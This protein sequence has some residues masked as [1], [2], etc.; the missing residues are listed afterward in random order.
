MDRPGEPIYGPAKPIHVVVTVAAAAIARWLA[1]RG[2]QPSDPLEA[3]H[4]HGHQIHRGRGRAEGARWICMGEEQLLPDLLRCWWRCAQ[5]VA[6]RWW[7]RICYWRRS[8]SCCCTDPRAH[9]PREPT[10]RCW[11]LHVRRERE[12]AIVLGDGGECHHAG[13]GG[14][15]KRCTACA[16]RAERRGRP[17]GEGGAPHARR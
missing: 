3:G 12:S 17:W 1:T 16:P 15:E 13:E 14:L 8:S 4:H 6:W 9:D 11:G 10:L 5:W 7:H 2:S